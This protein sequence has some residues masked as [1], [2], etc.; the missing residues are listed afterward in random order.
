MSNKKLLW[1]YFIAA[2]QV[3]PAKKLNPT[4]FCC[5]GIFFQS[6]VLQKA[7]KDSEKFRFLYLLF[8][9]ILVGGM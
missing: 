4:L 1:Q 8:K 2:F 3:S 6:Q 7:E 5:Y 9:F